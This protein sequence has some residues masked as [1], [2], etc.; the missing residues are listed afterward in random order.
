MGNRKV[1]GKGDRGM[2]IE[3]TLNGE[4]AVIQTEPNSRFIDLL[5]GTFHLLG[6]KSNCLIGICGTCSIIFNGNVIKSCLLP[7]F[8]VHESEIIT[9]EGFSK[10]DA[11]QDIIKGFEKAGVENCGYCDTGKI[12]TIETILTKNRQPTR[13]EILLGFRGIQCRCTE[14]VSLVEAVLATA[15][16]RQRRIYGRTA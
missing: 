11:Y 10:T 8:R 14:P 16:I 9:I 15:D 5:R 12:L 6:A 7:A 3:F 1:Q 2:T 4:D 13:N